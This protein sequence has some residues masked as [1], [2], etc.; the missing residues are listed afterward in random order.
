MEIIREQLT[1][2]KQPSNKSYCNSLA[3][4]LTSL[5][6]IFAEYQNNFGSKCTFFYAISIFQCTKIVNFFKTGY[7]AAF[8]IITF[9][10][11]CNTV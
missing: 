2:T 11:K 1:I 4:L 7:M 8:D 9:F 3:D 10:S 6:I 5:V